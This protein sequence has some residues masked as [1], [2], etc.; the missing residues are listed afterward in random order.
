[1]KRVIAE[2]QIAWPPTSESKGKATRGG[3][4]CSRTPRR[5]DHRIVDRYKHVRIHLFRE[6]NQHG[7]SLGAA[8]GVAPAALQ[9]SGGARRKPRREAVDT[10]PLGYSL[11]ALRPG[12]QVLGAYTDAPVT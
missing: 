1:M 2:M 9:H 4:S 11:G 3:S 10:W 7:Q 12:H 5:T 8:E 6:P